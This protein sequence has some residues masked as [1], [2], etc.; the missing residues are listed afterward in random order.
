MR[1]FLSADPGPFS[2][3]GEEK[4]N[5]EPRG[6]GPLTLSSPRWRRW[7]GAR[8]PEAAA[9]GAHAEGQRD[10]LPP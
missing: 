10:I 4:D 8:G 5:E 3:L 9:H 6:C 1:G 2:S 7:R